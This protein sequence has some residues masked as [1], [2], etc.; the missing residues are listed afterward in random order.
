MMKSIIIGTVMI[1]YLAKGSKPEGGTPEAP[2]D[3]ATAVQPLS[4]LEVEGVT[5]WQGKWTLPQLD[6]LTSD[7]QQEH[8]GSQDLEVEDSDEKADPAGFATCST[9]CQRAFC[10]EANPIGFAF[11]LGISD[12]KHGLGNLPAVHADCEAMTEQ[13][14]L[15]GWSVTP[16]HKPEHKLTLPSLGEDEKVP[17][18]NRTSPH[19][20]WKD[21]IIPKLQEFARQSKGKP[22]IFYTAGHEC[23]ATSSFHQRDGR[24]GLDPKKIGVLSTLTVA[25]DDFLRSGIFLP[26]LPKRYIS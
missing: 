6:S 12:Y 22:V 23:S 4:I 10:Q 2:F 1:S 13:L 11:V 8:T 19:L 20:S 15:M 7:S 5:E 16:M 25:P 26:K 18:D 9:F 17:D 21:H 24:Q 3:R 14:E